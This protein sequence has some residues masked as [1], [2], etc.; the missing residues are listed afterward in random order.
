MTIRKRQKLVLLG[1]MGR[2][3]VAGAVWQALHYL[4]GFERLGYEVYY[5]EAHG[6]WP[7]AF[8]ENETEAAAF[9]DSVLRRFDLGERWAFHAISG[10]GS[11]YGMSEGEVKRLYASAA[12]IFNLHGGTVPTP[13]QSAGQ[14]LV[15]IDTDPVNVQVEVHREV[16][17]TLHFLEQ[18]CAFFTFAENYGNP[19]CRL[20]VSSRFRFRPT[21]QPV[22]IDFWD[23]GGR[24]VDG[25]FTTIGN[26]QQLR[27][28]VV[29]DGEEF[30]WSKHLEFLKFLDLPRRTT[31]EF[32]LA[33]SSC[34][35]ASRALLVRNG[36]VVDDAFGFSHDP[37]AYRNYIYGSRG[38]FT[39][40]KDQNI[41]FRTGWFSDRSATYLAAGRPVITQDTGFPNILPTGEGLFAFAGMQDVLSAVEAINGDYERHSR[42]AAQI[43]RECFSH[44]VVLGA[45]LSH[46]NISNT[47]VGRRP[48]VHIVGSHKSGTGMG[49]VGRRYARAVESAGARAFMRD[50]GVTEHDA[51]APHGLAIN[52]ICSP[53]ASYFATRSGLGEDFFRGRYNIGVW[54]W[55]LATFPERWYDRFAYFDEIWAPSSFIASV[56]APVSPVPVLRI[57]MPLQPEVEG[58]RARGRQILG[59]SPAEFAYAFVF[60]F[61]SRAERK[62]PLGVID[63]FRRA[64]SA[65]DSVR[66]IIKC[67]HAD[68]NREY[69]SEM[70]TRA[71]GWPISIFDG[72]WNTREIADLIAACDCYV[73]LHRAEGIGLP[74][75]DA[76][77]AGK[78]VIATG[79]SGNMDFMN[80]ANSYPVSYE[81]VKLDRNVAHYPAGEIWAEPS[82]E[83]AAEMM[84]HVFEHREEAS[85]HGARARKDIDA[86]YSD[87]RVA[88]LIAR[89]MDL[90]SKRGKY[91]ALRERL[92]SEI[93]EART[94]REEFSDLGDYAPTNY[95]AYQEL[96]QKLERA[97][98]AHV[99]HDATLLV[100]S[101]GD[102]ELLRIHEGPAWHFPQGSG[103]AYAGH[104]PA[105]SAEAIRYVDAMCAEGGN[106]MLFPCTAFWWLEHYV[107]FRDHL[108][109]RYRLT[110]KDEACQ[111]FELSAVSK[112]PQEAAWVYG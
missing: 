48:N 12:V 82:L 36:W 101:K 29:F 22:V 75:A 70:Q 97:V 45:M 24:T 38:E 92:A 7:W 84:R 3:R 90:I 102:D 17:F 78:P 8:R 49:A 93:D 25:R 40:A 86:A 106:F 91:R 108:Y 13:E 60:D 53:I 77:A 94:F 57:P 46:L 41:R 87:H 80:V 35:D 1:M 43:G 96:K 6:C 33:L 69:F 32:E 14:R 56:L 47:V 62:N 16:P 107:A 63:S 109:H 95:F 99:P 58:D 68:F 2:M 44:D 100:V 104:Y 110:Y 9:I 81:L 67:S 11:Y 4:I 27:R 112:T 21:R 61:H 20:P 83:H 74:I 64:F 42:A 88:A 28:V 52:L 23:A 55:E 103:R 15:Y 66:L 18:H 73:S 37:D 76:M 72:D 79:W 71:T 59:L 111:V 54:L 19:D 85:A 5:V 34:D 51:A 89:R 65:G 26:W 31:Q 105:D 98:R 39:V 30:H 50:P 10:T